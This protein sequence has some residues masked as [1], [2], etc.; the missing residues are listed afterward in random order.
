MFSKLSKRPLFHYLLAI[1]TLLLLWT[2]ASLS[3]SMD[4][5]PLPWVAMHRFFTQ[6]T[7]G[8]GVHLGVSLCRTLLSLLVALLVAA[9]L[10]LITG[11]EPKIDRFTAPLLYLTSPVP[12]I[13][14]LPILL[15]LAGVGELSKLLL[16]AII[17][18]FQIFIATRDAAKGIHPDYIVSVRTL[19]ANRWQVYRH[20]VLP[21]CLPAI[22]SSLRMT[23]Q[24][25]LAVLFLSETYA[26]NV[27]IGY[28]IMDAVARFD[29]PDVF[30][31][32]I[33]MSGLG[34]VLFSLLD[35][36]ESRVCAWRRS[37]HG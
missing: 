27:G 19:G 10:G 26:T 2:A 24:I 18:F 17:A 32:I 36:V 9:P 29:Y 28:Y 33:G 13:A 14:F 12:K 30:A 31:G 7:E 25:A 11:Q 4:A 5:L 8:L 16:V 34:F 23:V 35:R 22:L 21:A 37:G 1:A 20:V 3:I 6:F 15:I